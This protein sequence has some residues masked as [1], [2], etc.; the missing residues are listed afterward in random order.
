[1]TDE[2]FYLKIEE[3]GEISCFIDK[4]TMKANGGEYDATCTREEWENGGCYAYV[5]NGEIVIGKT[6][7]MKKAELEQTFRDARYI[8]LRECDKISPMRWE[9]MSEQQKQAW[10][11][12]RQ[13]LLDITDLPGFPWDG[14]HNCKYWP[15]KPD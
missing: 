9:A 14:P 7:E 11:D 10:R 2:I 1:M 8:R 5:K 13:A 15:K 6:D 12:Y 3:D 4:E